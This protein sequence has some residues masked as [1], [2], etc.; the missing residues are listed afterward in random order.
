MEGRAEEKVLSWRKSTMVLGPLPDQRVSL[1]EHWLVGSR[2]SRPATEGSRH[3]SHG[4]LLK[5]TWKLHVAC[6]TC[7]RAQPPTTVSTQIQT[8][9]RYHF[10]TIRLAKIGIVDT[11]PH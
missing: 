8:T 3:H 11:V 9:M 4:P 5:P 6:N 1:S 10:S 2:V 7:K